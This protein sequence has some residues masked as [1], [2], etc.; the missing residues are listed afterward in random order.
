[1]IS[2][3][4]SAVV[5]GSTVTSFSSGGGGATAAVQSEITSASDGEPT[6]VSRSAPPAAVKRENVM[7]SS[8]YVAR[9]R[10][11]GLFPFG[12]AERPGRQ[13]AHV[14]WQALCPHRA[15]DYN[16]HERRTQPQ[17]RILGGTT[18]PVNSASLY[19][20]SL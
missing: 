1:M 13:Y 12:S 10:K 16:W 15:T 2:R 3:S 20:F 8:L 5:E 11:S 7:M 17:A 4:S 18:W 9:G 19:K 14:S 6:K